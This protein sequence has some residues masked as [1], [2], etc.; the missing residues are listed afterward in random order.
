MR[1]LIISQYFHPE[2][3]NINH[4][5]SDLV[6]KGHDVTVLTGMPNYPSGQ[7]AEGY[8]GW[9]T[10]R[11]NY[12]GV[13]VIR[14]PIVARGRDSKLGL[15][16]NYLSYAVTASLIAPWVVRERPDVIFVYQVSPLTV[17]LPAL[18]MRLFAR[19]PIVLWVQD[20]WPETLVALKVVKSKFS[21]GLVHRLARAIYR[22]CS[23]I[24]VQSPALEPCV[25]PLCRAETPIRYLPQIV[26]PDYRPVELSA[27]DRADNAA[28]DGFKVMYAGNVGAAQDFETILNAAERLRHVRDLRWMIVG[29]GR[30][31]N[32]VAEEIE[33]RGLHGSIVLYEQSPIERMPY[34]LAMADVLLV[35]LSPNCISKLIIPSKL[36]SCLA[37]G[38]PIVGNLDGA[39]ADVVLQS[40]AGLVCSPGDPVALADTVMT[41][42]GMD[43]LQRIRMGHSG[44]QYFRRHFEHSKLMHQLETHLADACVESGEKV[45]VQQAA[46]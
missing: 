14:V 13:S 32:W 37:T 21:V 44:L 16:F 6:R 29:D 24:L 8:G 7:F 11:E 27:R 4:I 26:A 28:P 34:L 3:F 31:R 36:Q 20:L 1:V 15:F 23:L 41:L 10:R 9:R 19:V 17:G 2:N 25:R 33:R 39:A 38:K 42:Y 12:S 35:S 45:A 5:A 22:R 30:M 46:S 40:K 18:V 43:P